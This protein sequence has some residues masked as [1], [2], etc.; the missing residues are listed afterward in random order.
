MHCNPEYHIEMISNQLEQ[1]L[2]IQPRSVVQTNERSFVYSVNVDHSL[3]TTAISLTKIKPLA[4][5]EHI[6]K[7]IAI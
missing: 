6:E 3:G 1:T 2:F 7:D 5:Y 4:Q